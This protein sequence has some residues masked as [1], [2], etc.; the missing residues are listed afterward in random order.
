MNQQFAEI[1]GLTLAERIQLVE[2][3][4]DSIAAEAEGLPLPDWQKAELARREAEYR[5]DPSLAG[6]WD[7]AKQRIVAKHAG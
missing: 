6:T 1:F 4:W 3:L 2:D 5:R 7:D